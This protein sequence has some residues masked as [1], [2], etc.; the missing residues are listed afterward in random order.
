MINAELI[1]T[2]RVM[3]S[4]FCEHFTAQ[5]LRIGEVCLYTH[6]P[7]LLTAY[8]WN[9]VLKF[10][11]RICAANLFGQFRSGIILY[12]EYYLH[13]G[14]FVVLYILQ[15]LWGA[16][17]SVFFTQYCSGDKIENNEMG[18]AR[19]AYG[20]EE[21]RVQGFSGETWGKENTWETQA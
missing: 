6:L 3:L 14:H 16:E 20:R 2:V 13:L 19:S 15:F 1:K 5:R 8:C 12:F 17:W 4:L 21:R 9:L 18:L 7:K 10:C 11:F